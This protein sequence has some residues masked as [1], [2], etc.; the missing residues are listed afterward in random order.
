M[1]LVNTV[2]KVKNR[3]VLWLENGCAYPGDSMT[4]WLGAVP[5]SCCLAS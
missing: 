2:L 5:P 4:D 1:R 3:M